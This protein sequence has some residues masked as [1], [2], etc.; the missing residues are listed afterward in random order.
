MNAPF[1][2]RSRLSLF[3]FLSSLVKKP[4]RHWWWMTTDSSS[5]HPRATQLVHFFQDG[6]LDSL[7]AMRTSM[8]TAAN[9]WIM[10]LITCKNPWNKHFSI[11]MK[12][13]HFLES[14][15]SLCRHILQHMHKQMPNYNKISHFVLNACLEPPSYQK[16][17]CLFCW[18]TWQLN[19]TW[20]R[21]LQA[22]NSACLLIRVNK[23]L[24]TVSEH[25]N[26][27]S[28]KKQKRW[29]SPM[30]TAARVFTSW[31]FFSGGSSSGVVGVSVASQTCFSCLC[32]NTSRRQ[33][34]T[35]LESLTVST[36]VV[37]RR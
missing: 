30:E 1:L 23:I 24:L 29:K 16:C 15:K 37:K 27:K 12:I 2:C 32:P 7:S 3:H 9:L 10:R 19:N 4:L 6:S 18:V 14:S 36:D 5:E 20:Y 26:L 28:Q 25:I 35:S 22:V 11:Q 21:W 17:C 13:K 33:L 31:L 8:F 34:K